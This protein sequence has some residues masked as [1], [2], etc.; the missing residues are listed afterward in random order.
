MGPALDWE[1]LSLRCRRE[2]RLRT[3]DQAAADDVAQEALLRAWRAWGRGARP[4][5]PVAW[6]L[7][8]TR[9][10][11]ARWHSGPNA[12]SWRTT[13]DAPE[14]GQGDGEVEGIIERVDVRDVLETLAPEDQLLLSLRY[15]HDLTQ[16]EVARRLGTPEGTAKV[17]LHRVRELLRERLSHEQADH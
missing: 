16:A 15:E 3:A 9:R 1:E 2:A 12:R 17:R 10:E 6:V 11:A 8:I 14:L 7:T 13:D 5:C 4:A